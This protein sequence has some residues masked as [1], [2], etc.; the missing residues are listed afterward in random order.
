VP[1]TSAWPDEAHHSAAFL[2]TSGDVRWAGDHRRV[3]EAR[4]PKQRRAGD[5]PRFSIG[6]DAALVVEG[7][8]RDSDVR[9]L[10]VK[11]GLWD[12][13]AR[14][15][16]MVCGGAAELSDDAAERAR[17]VL[18]PAVAHA[19][20]A[21]NAVVLD[22]GTAAGVMEIV[23]EARKAR[24]QSIPRLIGVAPRGRVAPAGEDPHGRAFL[25]ANHTHFVLADAEDWGGET[26]LMFRVAAELA[27]VE[28]VAV[29]VVGGGTH[30]RTEALEA[31]RRGWPIVVIQGSGD[32]ADEIAEV[33]LEAEDPPT[34]WS[35]DPELRAIV[36]GDVRVFDGQRSA[37]LARWLTWELTHETLKDAWA[38]FI[39]YDRQAT[40]LRRTFER[41]QWTII[42]LGVLATAL[43]IAYQRFH[44]Q[45]L[46]WL[47]I[48]AP[49]AISVTIAIA[50]R[51]GAGRRW[52]L[53]RAAAEAVKT[54]I[55]R[56]RTSR[57]RAGAYDETGTG[58]S[59]VE[60]LADALVA[61][62]TPLF[63][64]D[65]S[66]GL[67]ERGDRWPP[68]QSLVAGPDDG[69]SDLDAD[70]YLRHRL[71]DQLNYY[72]RTVRRLDRRRNL[73][74]VGSLIMGG[75]GTALA[76]GGLEVLIAVTTAISA[77]AISYLSTLQADRLI[78]AFNQSANQLEAIQRKWVARRDSAG[79][80]TAFEHLFRDTETV[81]TTDLTRWV[82]QMIK[83]VQ[84][85]EARSAA[86]EKAEGASL[87][88]SRAVPQ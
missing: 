21:C 59:R 86:D 63:R 74:Q 25:D 16:L 7:E 49:S 30:A 40:L 50:N 68:P 80:A 18:E 43:A 36:G 83:A 62:D 51:G 24:P 66:S 3:P 26:S 57:A 37:T 12:G 82:Q 85:Q 45:T 5:S 88:A 14:P 73:A 60:L 31:R 55:F 22:G 65:A 33:A 1:R 64:T 32:L 70:G 84:D 67:L 75:I 8:D 79:E 52:V 78:V 44:G 4:P 41:F 69:L 6:H 13:V 48:V 11:V 54:E 10:L 20:G 47:A 46:K 39:G 19:A 87:L 72:R 28:P 61:V 76:A 42:A 2:G 71:V 34:D 38:T 27:A 35:P 77:G 56:Y 81:L 17:Q 58:S 23:G 9:G 15:V 29:V 53:L